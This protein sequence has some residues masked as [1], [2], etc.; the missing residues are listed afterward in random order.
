[1]VNFTD[2]KYDTF[3]FH[4]YACSLLRQG[5][6]QIIITLDTAD[7]ITLEKGSDKA[8]TI[9]VGKLLLTTVTMVLC[10]SRC[11]FFFIVAAS[12][13]GGAYFIFTSYYVFVHFRFCCGVC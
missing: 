2:L 11:I 4:R 5:M 1:M 13:G 12:V 9:K 3:L 8:A 7:I 10:S 6:K